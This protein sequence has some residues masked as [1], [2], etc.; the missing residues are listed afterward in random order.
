MRT[1]SHPE[2]AD[3][4]EIKDRSLQALVVL[5]ISLDLGLAKSANAYLLMSPNLSQ[6]IAI[7]MHSGVR[8]GKY[9]SLLQQVCRGAP[10]DVQPGP[11]LVDEICRKTKCP[12]ERQRLIRQ[13]VVAW[14][15]HSTWRGASTELSE[16]A[17][18]VQPIEP[19]LTDEEWKPFAEAVGIDM[20][21]CPITGVACHDC[22]DVCQRLRDTAEATGI[23][24]TSV[25]PRGT[26]LIEEPVE[27]VEVPAIAHMSSGMAYE[28][29]A[30]VQRVYSDL[31]PPTIHCNICGEQLS[32]IRAVG[33]HRRIHKQPV[34]Q[35]SR[36]EALGVDPEWQVSEREKQ[37]MEMKEADVRNVPR[38]EPV[39]E[40]TLRV[41]PEI[42]VP[43]NVPMPPSDLDEESAR[44]MLRRIRNIVA[45]DIADEMAGLVQQVRDVTGRVEE[46][47]RLLDETRRERDQLRSNLTAL[48]DMIGDLTNGKEVGNS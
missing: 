38:P 43:T 25:G 26:G 36:D 13:E 32:S 23:V 10:D 34:G 39:R 35:P 15:P 12:P 44:D 20:T 24:E 7:P 29:K 37:A 4:H 14:W 1:I 3:V 22:P 18:E 21:T 17:P 48:R 5:G 6:P 30:A 28:S 46:A 31:R 42:A 11:D 45:A 27:F 19:P 40:A 33:G 9:K 2:P 41:M 16:G 8:Q 47:E